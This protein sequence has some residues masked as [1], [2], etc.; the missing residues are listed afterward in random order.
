MMNCKQA[1][2]LVSHNLDS[3]LS[4]GRRISLKLHL[5]MCHLCRN[6]ARQ[7]AFLHRTA[8]I[9]ED[10]IENMAELHLSDQAKARIKRSLDEQS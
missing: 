10:H 3:K 5:M 9:I 4:L 6:Y 8:P 7:L 2:E 1:T